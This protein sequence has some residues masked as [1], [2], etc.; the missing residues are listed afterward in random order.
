MSFTKPNN[1]LDIFQAKRRMR[2]E[3]YSTT[4]SR[5]NNSS[6]IGNSIFPS[7]IINT[8]LVVSVEIQDTTPPVVTLNGNASATIQ[9]G[10]LIPNKE[11]LLM[12]VKV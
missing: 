4:K 12:V 1:E 2:M 10:M 5:N 9:Q 7:Q 3:D 6:N 8:E 11:L